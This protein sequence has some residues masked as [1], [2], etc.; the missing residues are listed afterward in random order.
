[1]CEL[2]YVL[3]LSTSFYT[4]FFLS[5]LRMLSTCPFIH[6]Y[7]SVYCQ[8]NKDIS[9][10]NHCT[11]FKIRKLTLIQYCDLIR[12]ILFKCHQLSQQCLL[13]I[14]KEN[15]GSWP[16]SLYFFSLLLFG[17]SLCFMTLIFL[18]GIGQFGF[19]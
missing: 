2:F 11:I 12:Q 7:F 10:H 4:Q 13:Y 5:C 16:S 3:S 17:Y 1:M 9:F 8:D 19:V 15:P 18:K 6:K 14:T